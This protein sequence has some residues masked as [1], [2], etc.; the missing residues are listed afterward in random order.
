ML[1]NETDLDVARVGAEQGYFMR[2]ATYKSGPAGRFH[3]VG[4]N[5]TRCLWSDQYERLTAC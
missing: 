2:T 5:K 3:A 1:R 4:W